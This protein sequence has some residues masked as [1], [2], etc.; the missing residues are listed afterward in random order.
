MVL[1]NEKIKNKIIIINDYDEF[2]IDN[3]S[4]IFKYINKL[5]ENNVVILLTR[6]TDFL[7][8][9]YKLIKSFNF[10]DKGNLCSMN[11]NETI[12]KKYI[13]TKDYDGDV[14]DFNKYEINSQY[15]V[16]DKDIEKHLEIFSNALKS[17]VEICINSNSDTIDLSYLNES[18][19]MY[20]YILSNKESLKI[21]KIEYK[22]KI[23]KIGKYILEKYLN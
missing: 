17:I 20:S 7:R 5:T 12:I 13:L 14:L 19:T 8:Q 11:F 23:S 22:N 18:I 6:K 3:G 1:G 21:N 2:S 15:L 9:N 4:S 10:L 16:E